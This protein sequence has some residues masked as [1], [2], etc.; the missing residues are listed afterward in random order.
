MICTATSTSP[1]TAG[2][3]GAKPR[4]TAER[5][6]PRQK[7]LK[8]VGLNS[9]YRTARPAPNHSRPAQ[10]QKLFPFKRSDAVRF[11]KLIEA[12]AERRD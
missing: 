9:V 8:G 10:T 11:P 3:R 12:R 4:G 2:H 7:F 5:A 6:P 1:Q